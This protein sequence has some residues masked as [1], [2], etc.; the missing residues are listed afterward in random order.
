VAPMVAGAG[1]A[2]GT[3]GMSKTLSWEFAK[4]L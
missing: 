2:V 3:S 1:P 4:G